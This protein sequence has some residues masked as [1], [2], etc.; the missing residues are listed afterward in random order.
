MTGRTRCVALSLS[1]VFLVEQE[2]LTLS[3]SHPQFLNV[4]QSKDLHQ[5]LDALNTK[6]PLSQFE[7]ALVDFIESGVRLLGKPAL[8]KVRRTA[9]PCAAFLPHPRRGRH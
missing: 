1:A 5:H 8:A 2:K 4:P 3:L 9:L 7:D 6:Y